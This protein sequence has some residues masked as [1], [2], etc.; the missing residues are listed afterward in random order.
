[1]RDALSD[2]KEHRLKPVLLRG[3]GGFCCGALGAN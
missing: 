1:L 2:V 3:V